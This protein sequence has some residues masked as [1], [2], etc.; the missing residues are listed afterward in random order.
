MYPKPWRVKYNRKF[1]EWH[2]K[3]LPTV[4]AADETVVCEFPQRVIHPGHFDVRAEEAAQTIVAAINAGV[5][6]N[7]E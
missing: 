5:D 7:D 4:V 3:S 1:A 2:E 6:D